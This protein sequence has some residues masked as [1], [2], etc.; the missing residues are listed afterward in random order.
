M[1]LS[2]EAIVD[3]ALDILSQYGLA[4]VSMRRIAGVL[5]VAPGAL[6]W[7]IENKQELIAALADAII[8]PVVIAPPED[9]EALC[10]ALWDHVLTTRDGAEIVI[11]AI[12][13][14]DASVRRT[15]EETFASVVRKAAPKGA[16]ISDATVAANGLLH[17]TL[18]AAAVQQSATQLATATGERGLRPVDEAAAEHAAAV[19]LL[20]TGM[21]C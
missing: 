20:L 10:A 16:S 15:L 3:T 2:R 4:D 12:G 11:S 19:K 18:G 8:A 6:Y 17:L 9:P 21:K 13:Q 5:G 14:P 1:Q 7:H